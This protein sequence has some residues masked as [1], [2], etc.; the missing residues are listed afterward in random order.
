[1]KDFIRGHHKTLSD[2]GEA[3]NRHNRRKSVEGL[4]EST[5]SSPQG[6][7]CRVSGCFF[8]T[9]NRGGVCR[10]C[11]DEETREVKR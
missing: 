9:V 1:M 7:R 11:L 10:R 5:N 2:Y 3:D 4:A 6:V 8:T